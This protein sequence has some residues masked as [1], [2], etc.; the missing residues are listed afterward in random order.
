MGEGY[1]SKHP[2]PTSYA[3]KKQYPSLNFYRIK[4]FI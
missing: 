2:T 4:A 1:C 3:K